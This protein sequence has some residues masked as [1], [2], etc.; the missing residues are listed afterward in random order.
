ME[1]CKKQL[2]ALEEKNKIYACTVAKH[3]QSIA[4][5]REEAMN[6]QQLLAR[7]EVNVTMLQEEKQLLKDG[8]QRLSIE[9][10][11]LIS[12]RQT[13]SLLHANLE[14][15][16]LNLERGECETRM[17]L[18]NSVT[19][20]E[21]QVELLRKKLDNEEQR[22][23][24]TV[25]SYEGRLESDRALLRAAEERATIAQTQLAA[26]EER[27]AAAESRPRISSP[28]R[29]K[30]QVARLLSAPTASG[31][32]GSTAESDLLGDLRAQL[33][34]AQSEAAGIREQLS[35]AS[36]R[37][38]QYRSI[39]DSME[40]QLKKN[41]EANLMFKQ[42]SE[43]RLRQLTE[44]RDTLTTQLQEAQEKLKASVSVLI[45]PLSCVANV[46]LFRRAWK[47]GPRKLD[48]RQRTSRKPR[49]PRS[50][51]WNLNWLLCRKR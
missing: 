11:A 46:L 8:E 21:Q 18:Q 29:A 35:L 4:L 7:A 27:A 20:L 15:I 38:D 2:K 23:R 44:E 14:S 30:T 49:R 45:F 34:D 37:A 39:A 28:I 50:A 41:N 26:A 16:K 47:R 13:Q 36:Q 22:Y 17:R 5:L 33:S 25:K 48:K 42:E 12:Q 19:S 43:Q 1:S 3:E 51:A 40:E 10:D 32:G 24:D 31:G 6:T 9:R